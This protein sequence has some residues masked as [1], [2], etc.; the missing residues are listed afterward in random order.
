MEVVVS[1]FDVKGNVLWQG[2]EVGEDIV[3]V[4]QGI[5]RDEMAFAQM[6]EGEKVCGE[7]RD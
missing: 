7:V 5:G 6:D 4:I 3:R 1:L 2:R